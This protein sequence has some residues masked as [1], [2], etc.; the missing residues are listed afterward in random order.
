MVNIPL[1]G[2]KYQYEGGT[3]LR[4]LKKKMHIWGIIKDVLSHFSLLLKNQL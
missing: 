3:D 2:A 4:E 1:H